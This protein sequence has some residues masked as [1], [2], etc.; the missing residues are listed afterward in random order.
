MKRSKLN[1]VSKS[2]FKKLENE[3]WQECRRI[4]YEQYGNNCYTCS[5]K[6]LQGRNAHTGHMWPKGSLGASLKYDI[7]ILRPQCYNCNIN[8]GGQGAIFIKKMEKEEGKI[9]M[10]KLHADK[11]EDKKGSL[12]ASDYY[13]QL[14]LEYRRIIK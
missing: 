7:R 1:K 2:S 10:D 4:T 3:L 5:Q 9:Y 8:Y 6:N 11:I 13:P 14:L 12:K